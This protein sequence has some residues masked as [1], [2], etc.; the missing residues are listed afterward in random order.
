TVSIPE[1]AAQ[2]PPFGKKSS[3][4]AACRGRHPRPAANSK[5]AVTRPQGARPCP[6]VPGKRASTTTAACGTAPAAS[7]QRPHVIVG[8]GGG[9][10]VSLGASSSWVSAGTSVTL[11][12]TASTDVGPTPYFIEILRQNGS[13]V[14]I[15]GSGTTCATTVSAS[16]GSTQN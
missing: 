4:A 6:S 3:P 1:G 10:S 11:T 7:G 14:A 12:A 9:Y 15:C 16:G 8:G 13:A 2:C 5:L